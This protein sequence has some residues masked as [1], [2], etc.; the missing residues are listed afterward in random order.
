MRNMSGIQQ[1]HDVLHDGHLPLVRFRDGKI[2]FYRGTEDTAQTQD[3][4]AQGLTH[5]QHAWL[6]R[7]PGGGIERSSQS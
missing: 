1:G 6:P 7:A 5:R 3:P 4:A 2:Y